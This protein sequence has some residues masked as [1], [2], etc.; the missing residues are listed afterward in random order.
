MTCVLGKYALYNTEWEQLGA[1][2]NMLDLVKWH[3]AEEIEHRSVAFDLYCHLGGGYIARYYL[4][5]VVIIGVIGLWVDGA[6]HLLA[7][8]PRFKQLK[9]AVYKPW[10]W[11][12]WLRISQQDNRLLPNPLWLVSQ[13][14]G[15]LMPWYDPV[16]EG[17]TDD[18]LYYL[19]HSPAAKR[20][21][22]KVA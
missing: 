2:A 21:G 12:E 11:K 13:Q 15:Y 22:L 10:I 4:S 18:A 14:L 19:E 17:S 20:A 8:D 16:H 5:V 1:D 7:Q 3:G 6:A 9:P